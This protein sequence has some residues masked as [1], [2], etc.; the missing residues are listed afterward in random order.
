M[1][2]RHRIPE[3]MDDPELS[4]ALHLEALHG[5]QRINR[6][7]G[8]AGVVWKPIR[9][10]FQTLNK[11]QLSILD[12]ATGA[13]DVPVAIRRLSIAAG[14][15]V[16]IEACDI[17]PRAVDVAQRNSAAKQ[18]DIRCFQMDVL[19]QDFRRDYDV[20]VCATFLHH[21][22][23]EQAILVLRKMLRVAKHQVVVVD[24][25]R[26]RLNWWQVWLASHTLSRSKVVHFD[27]P[28]S[29]RA[30]FTVAEVTSLARAAG[31][32][33]FDIREVWP[34]RFVLVGRP[35]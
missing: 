1:K 13:G 15:R 16:D 28:Q 23:E 4:D 5:L 19:K 11:Q 26:S 21:L 18:T 8:N 25:V 3:I 10:L 14:I 17:S 27:G 34:C 30:A 20:V 33:D 24:L 31:W 7:T 6:W 12:V 29:V 22:S 32:E 35:H 9:S 2:H